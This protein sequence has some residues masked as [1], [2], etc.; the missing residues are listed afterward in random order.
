MEII[1]EL[2]KAA[3]FMGLGAVAY[4]QYI[5]YRVRKVGDVKALADF[6]SY[7]AER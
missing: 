7:N 4:H 5:K 3:V 2:I 1:G 6:K